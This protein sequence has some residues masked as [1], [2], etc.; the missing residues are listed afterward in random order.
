MNCFAP[1]ESGDPPADNR[2]IDFGRII[3]GLACRVF[4]GAHH[5][6]RNI[7][8]EKYT[9]TLGSILRVLRAHLTDCT[10]NRRLG[11]QGTVF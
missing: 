11:A 4:V 6:L 7:V 1:P 5:G 2:E 10:K 3:F 8:P 9:C